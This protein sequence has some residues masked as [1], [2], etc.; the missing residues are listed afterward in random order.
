M[1]KLYLVP[2]I[3]SEGDWQNVLPAQLFQILTTT[4]HFIVEDVRTARRF[5]KLVNKEINIDECTF[6]EL[7]KRTNLTEIPFF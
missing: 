1:A 6:Y 3:L 5:L 2:N 4:K 7:N